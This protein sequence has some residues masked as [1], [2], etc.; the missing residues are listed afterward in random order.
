LAKAVKSMISKTPAS[1][2]GQFFMNGM[3]AK[4]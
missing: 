2:P 3:N 1:M 4:V